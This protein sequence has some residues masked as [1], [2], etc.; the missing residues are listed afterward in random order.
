[1][2]LVVRGDGYYW[3]GQGWGAQGRTFLSVASAAR[4]L[5]EGGEDIE[6]TTIIDLDTE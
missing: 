5:H 6:T 4:S 3:D 1:M 2:F